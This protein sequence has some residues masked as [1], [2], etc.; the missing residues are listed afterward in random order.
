MSVLYTLNR[1][2]AAFHDGTPITPADVVWSF[3]TLRDK[4]APLYRFYYGDVTRVAIAGDHGVRFSF[5]N[6]DNANC[7]RS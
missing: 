4:G 7:R 2:A 3:E 6:G 1:R 5:K